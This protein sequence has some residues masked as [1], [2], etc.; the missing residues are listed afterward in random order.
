M[1]FSYDQC[2]KDINLN[3]ITL[4]IPNRNN[5][6][7]LASCLDSVLKQSIS[8]FD[9]L[10]SDNGS[11][12]SSVDIILDK[13]QNKNIK[14][15]RTNGSLSYSE[16]LLWILQLINTEYVIFLAG[17]DIIHIDLLKIYIKKLNQ[18]DNKQ[19]PAFICSPFYYI[20]SNNKIVDSLSWPKNR[21]GKSQEALSIFLRG[22]ICNISSVAWS[23]QILL[24]KASGF[25]KY[26]NCIDWYLYI[27]CLEDNQQ[28][29]FINKKLLMYRIHNQSTG[30]SNVKAHTQKCYD[31]FL[32]LK[33][34]TNYKKE[35]LA[36]IDKNLQSFTTIINDQ[37]NVQSQFSL[38]K[39]IIKL[40]TPYYFLLNFYIEK[41][42]HF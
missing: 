31:M 5:E 26:G 22:P 7:Y 8:S 33:Q 38:K 42:C 11:T 19:L 29:L 20:N 12:D 21:N 15:V 18:S 30:N 4:A 34:N 28:A 41:K 40:L 3:R 37:A 16:H 6:K 27:S 10:I 13:I 17:D 24:Q 14:F 23:K 9:I 36:I 25:Q 35:D 2:F 1:V 32:D 39:I